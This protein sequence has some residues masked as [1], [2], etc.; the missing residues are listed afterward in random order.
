MAQETDPADLS[1]LDAK[2]LMAQGTLSARELADACI[3]RVERLNHA[4]NAL[5][6]FDLE[7][8]RDGAKAADEKRASGANL[9][10]LHGLPLAIKDMNDVAGLPTTYGSEIH[11]GNVPAGDDA[12]VARLAAAGGLPMAKSNN[13]EWSAGANTR[14]R[15]YG[16][17]ANPYD[18]SRNCGG[19]S[20][21]SAVSLA[22]GFA[23]LA[24]GSDLAGSLRTPAAYCGVVGFR[25]TVGV[26]PN[27][28]RDIGY[29][30]LSTAGPMART[31]ADCGLMLSVMSHADKRDVFTPVI[32]GRTL[33]TPRDFAHPPLRDL[34]DFRVGFT[35]DFGFALAEEAMRAVFR[36]GIARLAPHFAQCE[37]ATPDCA[38]ADRLISVLRGMLFVV[39]HGA[40]LQ[41]TPELVGE[42]VRANV[43]EGR[44]AS[45]DDIREALVGYGV[46]GQ[47]WH[48][49][50]ERY[51]ILIAPAVSVAAR[52][53]REMYPKEIDGELTTSYY[54]WLGLAYAATLAGHP[55]IS[56]PCGRDPND[57]PFGVQL[58]GRRHGDLD[59]L[60]FAMALEAIIA[61]TAEL[62][63]P[64][65]DL[66][67]L[68]KAPP[69]AEADGFWPA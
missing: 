7:R 37:E 22:C 8:L 12:L 57:L 55:A 1:A 10:P 41:E 23:P 63:P 45:A 65:L 31:V 61:D 6:A 62:S 47:R 42:N 66:D 35:E 25:P 38:D 26:V 43:A 53:W 60:S 34:S 51:D 52:D 2:R 39:D 11:R 28:D 59:L 49:F 64:A 17:T 29:M 27:A 32:E 15:V 69:L 33:W 36:D 56:I 44:E 3:A 46:Y 13:P 19:S 24:T 30:P 58:I 68:A 54:H 9:A 67:A 50:F 5:V 20:G 21:G 14:N 4:V 18:L 16:T 48:D 40:A